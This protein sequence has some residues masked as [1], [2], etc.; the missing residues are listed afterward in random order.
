MSEDVK[1]E[2]INVFKI[3]DL[4]CF[5]YFFGDRELFDGLSEYYNRPKYRFELKDEG[6]RSKVTS[7][8]KENGFDTVTIEDTA[9]YTVK[10]DRFKKY[11]P[12]LRNSIDSSEGEKERVFIMKDLASVEEAVDRG[13]EKV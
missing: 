2:K 6:E 9:E 13:A 11:A 5:K 7:Y 4:W 8:L 12:I 1:G 10:I 3:G